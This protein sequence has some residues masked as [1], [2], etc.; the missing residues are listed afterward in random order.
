MAT[1][2][3]FDATG[4]IFIN[5]WHFEVSSLIP[6]ELFGYLIKQGCRYREEGQCAP[7]LFK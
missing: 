1:A 4:I 2:T 5:V 3:I 7:Y 6:T